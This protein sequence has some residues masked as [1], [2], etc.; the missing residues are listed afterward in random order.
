[1]TTATKPRRPPAPAKRVQ[2]LR[3]PLRADVILPGIVFVLAA[4]ACGL[5][6]YI[7][8]LGAWS[9][10]TQPEPRY[11][12]GQTCTVLG[13]AVQ[14]VRVHT[15]YRP[16]QYTILTEHG[17]TPMVPEPVLEHCISREALT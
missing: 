13:R 6:A 15:S 9:M 14:V 16:P 5:Y 12:T 8:V 10:A 7:I 17:T 11:T 3:A 4:I 2:N 1:M